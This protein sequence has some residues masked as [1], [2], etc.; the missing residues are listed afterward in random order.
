MNL[1]AGKRGYMGE[2]GKARGK[3]HNYILPS[4]NKKYLKTNLKLSL[5]LSYCI[6]SE[7][8]IC[9]YIYA[10][11]SHLKTKHWWDWGNG[12]VV[13]SLAALP[14]GPGFHSQHCHG[15]PQS[16]GTP[17]PGHL[18]PSGL[19]GHFTNVGYRHICRSNIHTHNFKKRKKHGGGGVESSMLT[20][21][22]WV[23]PGR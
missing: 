6:Y 3:G 23:G 18:T 2:G 10:S 14:R 16:S 11:P 4:K 22:V 17:V 5:L 19:C 8:Y 12:S 9:V 13:R 21:L 7:I 15:T 1:R 20:E